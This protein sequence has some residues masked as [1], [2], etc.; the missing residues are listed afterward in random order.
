MAIHSLFGVEAMARASPTMPPPAAIEA[1]LVRVPFWA[2]PAVPR[3][4][5]VVGLGMDRVPPPLIAKLAPPLE[6]IPPLATDKVTPGLMVSVNVAPAARRS[7]LIV[8]LAETVVLAARLTF[9]V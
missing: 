3:L 5:T 2:A 8:V 4:V 7:E 9:S 6:R 1:P